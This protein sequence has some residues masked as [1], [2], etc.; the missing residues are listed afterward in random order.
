MINHIVL[1]KISTEVGHAQIQAV[2]NALEN[3]VNVIPGLLSFSGGQNNSPEGISRGFTHGF[4]MVFKDSSARDNYLP[5]P[6]HE[7]V[8][9]MIGKILS[10]CS[11]PVLVVDY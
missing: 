3:L 6:E 10:D 8:K 9:E 2:F 11:E 5:H 7:V 4:H 1:L